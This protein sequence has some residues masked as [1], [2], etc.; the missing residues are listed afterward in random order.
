MA[1]TLALLLLFVFPQI[2]LAD[3]I[4]KVGKP[5][6]SQP[7]ATT[8]QSFESQIQ[9][10]SYSN[11]VDGLELPLDAKVPSDEGF[12]LVQAK[13][14][15][16]V[17]WLVIRQDN[18]KVKTAVNDAANQ[19]TVSIPAQS[20]IISIYAVGSINGDLTEFART[21]LLVEGKGP[22]TP[23]PPNPNPDPNPNPNPNPK[24]IP[25]D[26]KLNVTVIL[27]YSA[28]TPEM[29]KL[30]NDGPMRKTLADKGHTLRIYDVKDRV[31]TDKKLDQAMA[32][33]N[34]PPPAIIV[35]LADG[36][37]TNVIPLSKTVTDFLNLFHATSGKGG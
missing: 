22:V 6:D 2:S 32:K 7:P 21:Q 1:R 11:R 4:I 16:P 12:V 26:A 3:E 18:V 31:V 29:A 15:G 23:L 25:I 37:V 34:V 20:C 14:E 5:E 19:I 9:N 28:V 33:F 17:R 27:D 35:Q 24:P 13:C 36:T 30:L 8:T 10:S